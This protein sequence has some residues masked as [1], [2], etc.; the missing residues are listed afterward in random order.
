MPAAKYCNAYDDV[1]KKKITLSHSETAL[2][3]HSWNPNTT[4]ETIIAKGEQLDGCSTTR[5]SNTHIVH[6]QK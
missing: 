3:L 4:S 1:K 5:S 6:I 2:K